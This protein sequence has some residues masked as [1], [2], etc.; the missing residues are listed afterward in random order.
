MKDASN[1]LITEVLDAVAGLVQ[2]SRVE[3][4]TDDGED[5]D[6]KHDEKADLHQGRQGLEYG[7]E[8]NLETCE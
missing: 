2:C 3:L 4:Q 6:G 7:L 1:C 8:D 5:Q